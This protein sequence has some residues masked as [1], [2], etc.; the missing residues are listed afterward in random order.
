MRSSEVEGIFSHGNDVRQPRDERLSALVQ[1]KASYIILSFIAFQRKGVYRLLYA[2][3]DLIWSLCTHTLDVNKLN[4]SNTLYCIRLPY[5]EHDF[6]DWRGELRDDPCHC[7]K[8]VSFS[9]NHI[10]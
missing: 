2:S 6:L 1:N 5:L 9:C 3:L 8:V 7:I 10:N 4:N